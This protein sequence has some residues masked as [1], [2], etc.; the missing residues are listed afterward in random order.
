MAF[1]VRRAGVLLEG[2]QAPGE[3][4]GAY[5]LVTTA[6]DCCVN[7]LLNLGACFSLAHAVFHYGRVVGAG[8]RNDMNKEL[9]TCSDVRGHASM[10][11]A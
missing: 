8:C 4:Y 10:L 3:G 1:T 2:W 5:L 9:G 11:L 7:F 6:A